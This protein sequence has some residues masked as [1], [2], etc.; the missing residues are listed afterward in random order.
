MN[1][2]SSAVTTEVQSIQ[3]IDNSISYVNRI[4]NYLVELFHLIGLFIIGLIV[5]WAAAKECMDI[6]LHGYPSLVDILLLFIYLELGAMIGVYFKTHELPVQ[7]FLYVAITALTR[8][9]VVDIK[10]MDEWRVMTLTLAIL[11]LVIAAMALRY[12]ASKFPGD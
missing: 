4:G 7:F 8:I 10:T 6:Y 9:L 5:I 1:T 11:V 12:S 2:E 3:E